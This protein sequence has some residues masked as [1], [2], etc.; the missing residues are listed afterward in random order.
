MRLLPFLPGT[1]M[2]FAV[3]VGCQDSG[4]RT[5]SLFTERVGGTGPKGSFVFTSSG[6]YG[7]S[8]DAITTLYLIPRSNASFTL[9][10]GDLSYGSRV[11]LV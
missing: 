7:S 3:A 2:A 11:R 6:D 10:L 4:S 8:K 9:A 5:P 1:L